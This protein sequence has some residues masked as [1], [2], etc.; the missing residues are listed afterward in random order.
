MSS[1]VQRR[2]IAVAILAVAALLAGCASQSAAEKAAEVEA[3]R[4]AAELAARTPPPISL[5]QSVAEAAS[6]YVA[7]TRDMASIEG[8]FQDPESIQAAI[9]RGS[10]YD[11]AQLSR[12][13]VA[14]ASIV[15]LQSPEFVRGVRQYA[16]DRA[17]REQLAANIAADP[18]WAAQLPGADAAAGLIMATLRNDIAALG[19][20]ADSIEND[21]YA[22]QARYDVRRSW[23]V[24]QVVDRERRLEDA[25]TRSMQAM[26]PSAE[27]SARLLSAAHSGSGLG[28][29]GDRRREPPYPPVVERALA[30]AALAALGEAGDAAR[31]R[32]DA[33]QNDPVSQ[34]CM[35]ESKLMLFQCLAASRPS[36]EDMFC[37]GRHIVRDL[38]T[39]TRG[40]S[41]PAG[42][43]MISAPEV[44]AVQAP[45]IAVSP[46]AEPTPPIRTPVTPRSVPT[47]APTLAPPATPTPTPI[48]P[49]Q[50]LN[51]GPG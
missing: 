42:T 26:L 37:L 40:A 50:R 11:P 31:A 2:G 45:R 51:T 23:A 5:N 28:V 6:I 43:V 38:A 4:Q 47:T 13:L 36:Y 22:I 20:A 34:G 41:M 30:L 15:A 29:S 1:V 44:S 48:S 7:F 32:T 16:V 12:G 3:A 9:R 19:V 25:K 8:G 39:C 33:L 21:A 18:R 46:L 14:Y 17:T 24:A 35:A 27:E 49:T 10:A